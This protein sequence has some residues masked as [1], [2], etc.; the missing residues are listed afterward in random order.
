V[1]SENVE[2]Y[3]G[4]GAAAERPVEETAGIPTRFI[5]RLDNFGG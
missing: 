5:K 3:A 1:V 4:D 2:E